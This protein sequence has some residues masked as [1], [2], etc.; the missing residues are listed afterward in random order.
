MM[1]LK[2]LW[3]S[4]SFNHL[5]NIDDSE[6]RPST[7]LLIYDD[8]IHIKYRRLEL[9]DDLAKEYYITKIKLK[10]SSNAECNLKLFFKNSK[11]CLGSKGL[12]R[13]E[14]IKFL[15]KDFMHT[16]LFSVKSKFNLRD[17]IFYK[18]K[19][20]K[21]NKSFNDL[22]ELKLYILLSDEIK[23]NII[24]IDINIFF[25]TAF[26][27]YLS[28]FNSVSASGNIIGFIL[29]T[30][31]LNYFDFSSLNAKHLIHNQEILI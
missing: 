16:I 30:D 25:S 2:R 5:S 3:R 19:A 14:N 12:S 1:G 23:E 21:K 20:R 7:D 15:K 10:N 22:N 26:N 17:H 24:D 28:K 8:P 13:A 6:V 27:F 18:I 9:F 11:T 31:E 29:K 4:L